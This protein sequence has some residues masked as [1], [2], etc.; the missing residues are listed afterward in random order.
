MSKLSRYP[1]VPAL[2]FVLIVGATNAHAVITQ[3]VKDACRVEYLSYCSAHELGSA[4]LRSCMRAAQN[5]LSQACLKELVA[6]GEV[7]QDEIRA[8]KARKQR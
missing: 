3:P 6:A 7:S 1:T 4:G 2:A 8:Y 5:Q